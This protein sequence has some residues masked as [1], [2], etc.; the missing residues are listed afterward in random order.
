MAKDKDRIV[1]QLTSRDLA[2]K[3]QLLL[4]RER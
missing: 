1:G 2:A 4:K 3:H